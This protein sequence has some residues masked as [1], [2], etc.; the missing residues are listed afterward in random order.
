METYA[1]NVDLL[2]KKW[3]G[4]KLIV[5][6]LEKYVREKDLWVNVS[7]TKLMQ[8][9]KREDRKKEEWRVNE[10]RVDEVDKFCYLQYWFKSN[11]GGHL[12]V[13]R[14][15]ERVSKVMGQI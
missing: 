10:K 4:V 7:K 12:N 2:A 11:G 15:L 6:K 14:R 8:F 1:D 13:C 5:K 9:S 3:G